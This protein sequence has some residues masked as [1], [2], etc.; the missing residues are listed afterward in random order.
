[1][2]TR[3]R[4]FIV[5]AYLVALGLVSAVALAM[6]YG[7][8][9]VRPRRALRTDVPGCY[10]L[11]VLPTSPPAYRPQLHA[12]S[13]VMLEAEPAA[14]G[15]GRRPVRTLGPPWGQGAV[16]WQADSLADTVRIGWSVGY[17]GLTVSVA[18][19]GAPPWYGRA[20]A[21]SG[22]DDHQQPLGQIRADRVACAR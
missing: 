13:F 18:V 22:F 7:R 3:P 5:S 19:Q 4:L 20:T 17:G 9:A 10:R 8:D 2:L 16:T 6:A 15:R 11:R 14:A 21:W 12:L 1:M